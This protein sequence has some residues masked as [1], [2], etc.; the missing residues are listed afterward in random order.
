MVHQLKIHTNNYFFSI[1]SNKKIFTKDLMSMV[2]LQKLTTD[3]DIIELHNRPKYFFFL[4]KK[5][6]DKNLFYIFITILMI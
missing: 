6:S 2:C 5:F 4:K 1:N 3:V